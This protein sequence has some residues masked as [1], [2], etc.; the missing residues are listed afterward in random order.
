VDALKLFVVRH[1]GTTWTAERRFTGWRDIALSDAGQARADAVAGAL[2]GHAVAAVYASPLERTRTTAEIVAKRHRLD[3]R[4]DTAFRD[5]GFG[6]WE[7]L[8]ADEVA[9]RSPDAW[10][11][12]RTAPHALAT[13]EGER[14]ADVA[15]R[16]G[17]ALAR[18]QQAHAGSTVVLVTHAVPVR[19]IVLAALGLG[20]ERLWSVDASPGGISEL[21]YTR[22][23]VTVHRMNT[24]AH[25]TGTGGSD[26]A[27][28][29]PPRSDAPRDTRGA[30]RPSARPGALDIGSDDASP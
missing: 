2:A 4:T 3:V 14:L 5:M 27:P 6:A 10:R 12:W 24:L 25:V 1:G 17:S 28:R 19:L 22:D 30:P 9:E 29:I 11:M 8:T 26:M 7:G 16:V 20:P 23:W 18:L 21:E 13:H 15:D